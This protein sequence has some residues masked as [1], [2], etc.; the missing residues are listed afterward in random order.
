MF[1]P[2][3]AEEET[4]LEVA[5]TVTSDG[6]LEL[7]VTITTEVEGPSVVDPDMVM[8][9]MVVSVDADAV[10]VVLV[11]F[12]NL[13]VV[14][15]RPEVVEVTLVD[16]SILVEVPSFTNEVGLSVTDPV[17]PGHDVALITVMVDG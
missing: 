1:D 10:E 14:V 3:V 13:V 17:N 16:D 4:P 2:N 15:V 12:V 5:V 8:V 6:V 11:E 9:A 7:A